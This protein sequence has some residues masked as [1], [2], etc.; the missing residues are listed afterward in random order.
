MIQN[1]EVTAI[2]SEFSGLVWIRYSGVLKAINCKSM[3]TW[4]QEHQGSSG[5]L[6]EYWYLDVLVVDHVGNAIPEA[7]IFLTPANAKYPAININGKP[8]AQTITCDGKGKTPKGHTPFPSDKSLESII[9]LGS[10]KTSKT[11]EKPSYSI[12]ASKVGYQDGEIKVS[13]DK[14]WYRTDADK[15]IKTIKITLVSQ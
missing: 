6:Y 15:P 1:K 2:D 11:T 4:I 8:L 14:D 3:K 9:I 10:E 7:K 13:A 12:K 5:H